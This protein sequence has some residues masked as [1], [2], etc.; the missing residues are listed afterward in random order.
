MLTAN[1]FHVQVLNDEIITIYEI[2]PLENYFKIL[3]DGRFL[4]DVTTNEVGKQV[5]TPKMPKKLFKSIY[6]EIEKL[7]FKSLHIKSCCILAESA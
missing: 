7:R 2:V 3:L 5:H 4:S 1:S 6:Q